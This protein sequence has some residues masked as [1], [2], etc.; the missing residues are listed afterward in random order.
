MIG[1]CYTCLSY[2]L[3]ILVIKSV[4]KFSLQAIR[5]TEAARHPLNEVRM[6]LRSYFT[7]EAGGL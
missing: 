5:G 1:I 2:F 4:L 6:H 7:W 3:L